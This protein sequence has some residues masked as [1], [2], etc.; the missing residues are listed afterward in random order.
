MELIK[1]APRGYCHG[2]ITAMN[3]VAKTLAD[4]TIEK[5]IYILGHIVHNQKITDAFKEAGA[6]TIEGENRREILE[7]VDHGTVVITAHGIDPSLIIEAKNRGLNVIDATC[8]DV[9]KTHFIINDR[10][11]KGMEVLYIGKKNHP[12]TEGAL[13]IDKERIHLIETLDD[14]ENSNFHG[15][16]LCITN[17]TTMSM[18]DNEAIMQAAASKYPDIEEICEICLATQQR[19][20]AVMNMAKDADLTIVVGDPKSN[21]SNRL[22]QVSE[23]MAGTKAIRINTI[24]DIDINM[25]L[26]DNVN[27]VAV[28]SG[29]STPTIITKEVC[30]FIEQFDKNN[31]NTWHLESKIV[32]Q[33]IIPRIR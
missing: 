27:K 5:P 17:Q 7:K 12:E 15:K 3:M 1:I 21:N 2:V 30:E 20:E 14:I 9:Y 4:K 29:A 11:A 8:S 33:K 16:K 23:E 26:D 24:E 18:W 22:V 32:L 28:T 31:K 25:L 10:L 19:Q 6:I 13:S